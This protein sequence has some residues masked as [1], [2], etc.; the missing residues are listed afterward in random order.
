MPKEDAGAAAGLQV[1]PSTP[2]GPREPVPVDESHVATN[3]LPDPQRHLPPVQ[4]LAPPGAAGAVGIAPGVALSTRGSSA[5]STPPDATML[6]SQEEPTSA[7]PGTD[8]AP[9]TPPSEP[10]PIGVPTGRRSVGDTVQ[11]VVPHALPVDA[12]VREVAT[13]ATAGPEGLAVVLS[14]SVLATTPFAVESPAVTVGGAHEDSLPGG[15]EPRRPTQ[16]PPGGTGGGLSAGSSGSAG[17]ALLALLS[18]FVLL[19]AGRCARL[20]LV[21]EEWQSSFY[22][23]LPER[24]G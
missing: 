14:A 17:G 8:P 15:A 9:V 18:V 24:P 21:P 12:P 13:Q 22:F 1:A 19:L 2:N 23:A 7:A 20:R 10:M 4:P 16:P 6:P 3:R 11:D 5:T